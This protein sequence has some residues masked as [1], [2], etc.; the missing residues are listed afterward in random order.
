MTDPTLQTRP[1]TQPTNAGNSIT[2][3]VARYE[4][5]EF[6]AA[7]A[8]FHTCAQAGD[9]TAWFWLST[10]HMN[11]DGVEVDKQTGFQCCLKAAEMGNV[12]AQ[13]NL[14][15]MY[16]Q[17]DGTAEDAQTG[18]T[19]LCRAADA[20]DTGAQFNAATLLSAGKVVDK[21]LAQAAEY[22]EMAAEAGYFPAQA[23]LG[24]SYRNGFGVAKNR[25][26]A[27]L[28]LSLASQHGA[29]SAISMLEGLVSEMSPEDLHQGHQ[30][31]EK[32]MQDHRSGSTDRVFRVDT[33]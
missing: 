18:L 17:G 13:T 32:W 5:A 20:G 26:K 8:I 7:Y 2:D 19:W 30:M 4:A 14:G 12:Q 33:N 15:V 1:K 22:Y 16:I 9:A 31:V 23:R 29:G 21:D 11:G 27:F 28:W 25:H 10:M 3:G 6:D 24:F